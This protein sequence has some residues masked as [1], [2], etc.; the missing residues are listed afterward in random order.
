[1]TED[2]KK[3]KRVHELVPADRLFDMLEQVGLTDINDIAR[4]LGLSASG[5]RDI[6]EAG[7]C[8]KVYVLAAE[9]FVR[10]QNKNAAQEWVLII[11]GTKPHEKLAV[12]AL[13]EAMKMKVTEI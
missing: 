8:R 9:C 4:E 7:K 11:K 5:I 10:R 13:A 12:T 2:A 3:N 1:M 6:K